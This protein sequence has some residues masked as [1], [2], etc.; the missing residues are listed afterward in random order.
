MYV[1]TYVYNVYPVP[2]R[3]TSKYVKKQYYYPLTG[4]VKATAK[5]V[6]KQYYYS[7][8]FFFFFL[9][10]FLLSSSTRIIRGFTLSP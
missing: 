6:K 5:D 7:Y 4:D 2:G 3:Y 1:C 8:P 9:P 10:S